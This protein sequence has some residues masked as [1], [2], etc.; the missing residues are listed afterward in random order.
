M[1]CKELLQADWHI[2]NFRSQGMGKL[3]WCEEPFLQS[4][5]LQ[6]EMNDLQGMS[7]PLCCMGQFASL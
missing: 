5:A 6:Y 3:M 7:L 4:S 1:G 2:S